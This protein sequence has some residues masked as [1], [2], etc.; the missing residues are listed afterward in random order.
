VSSPVDRRPRTFKTAGIAVGALGVAGLVA[1]IACGVVAKQNSDDL[2]ALGRS[3]GTFDPGKESAGK[4]LQAA[5]TAMFVVGAVAVVT[6][7]VL[8]VVGHRASRHAAHNA[9]RAE[10]RF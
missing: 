4:S 6:G 8:Y 1:G 2:T 3:G 10:L 7:V 9:A 5:E